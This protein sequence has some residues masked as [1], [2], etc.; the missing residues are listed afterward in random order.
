MHQELVNGQHALKG[1][2]EM[3]Q[4][5]VN[6]LPV[7]VDKREMHQELVNGQHALPILKSEIDQE[8]VNVLKD[9]FVL[10]L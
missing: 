9:K 4:E 1:K 7:Q 6:G 2:P 3:D 8:S 5:L 10:T